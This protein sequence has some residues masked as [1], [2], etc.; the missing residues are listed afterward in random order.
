MLP[1]ILPTSNSSELFD[2][3]QTECQDHWSS[4]DF[5]FTSTTVELEAL[6]LS[7]SAASDI[8][9]L[10]GRLR[11]LMPIQVRA[12]LDRDEQSY[13]YVRSVLS[14]LLPNP[15][16]SGFKAKKPVVCDRLSSSWPKAIE[17]YYN[18]E[19]PSAPEFASR[20]GIAR[21]DAHRFLSSLRLLDTHGIDITKETTMGDTIRLC[22]PLM[23]SQLKFRVKWKPRG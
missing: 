9:V 13:A 10:N 22:V 1:S 23:L 17:L 21:S 12:T 6:G 8:S 4:E 5:S 7:R 18:D 11:A 3:A 15:A 19:F 14:A 20:Y 16:H 2:Q